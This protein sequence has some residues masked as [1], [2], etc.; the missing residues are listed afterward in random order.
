MISELLITPFKGRSQLVH[1]VQIMNRCNVSCV[2]VCFV[3]LKSLTNCL[4]EPESSHVNEIEIPE[5]VDD[6]TVMDELKAA[7]ASNKNAG[8]KKGKKKAGKKKKKG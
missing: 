6:K 8:K 3:G 2:F 7:L 5:R 1:K 4:K